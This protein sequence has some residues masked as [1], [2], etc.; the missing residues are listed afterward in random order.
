MHSK[1]HLSYR[2]GNPRGKQHTRIIEVPFFI[3]SL[4][5]PGI[6]IADLFAT[7]VRRQE[8]L[9]ASGESC[10]FTE[11]FYRRAR[12]KVYETE[13]LFEE[14]FEITGYLKPFK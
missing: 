4:Y 3:N 13:R 7:I 1:E 2:F 14:R 9:M 6:Q 12:S 8:E 11:I 10:K 5:S